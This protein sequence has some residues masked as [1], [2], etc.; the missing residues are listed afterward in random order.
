[1][2]RLFSAKNRLKL[3]GTSNEVSADIQQITTEEQADM[4]SSSAGEHLSVANRYSKDLY[5]RP[6][7]ATET[8]QADEKSRDP[9]EDLFFRLKHYASNEISHAL[10]ILEDLCEKQHM[11]EELIEDYK[12]LLTPAR[13]LLPELLE[14]IFLHCIPDSRSGE[15]HWGRQ[16]LE[17]YPRVSIHE[18]PW[19][20]GCVCRQWRQ[21]ALSTPLI[22]A[23]LDV[24]S[25]TSII[26][27][28]EWLDRSGSS[29]LS[30]T[31]SEDH[32]ALRPCSGAM[33]VLVTQSERWE[34]IDVS[35]GEVFP[36]V[37]PFLALLSGGLPSLKTLKIRGPWDGN[38]REHRCFVNIASS[39]RLTDISLFGVNLELRCG[40]AL[41]HNLR[42]LKLYGTEDRDGFLS[43]HPCL[44]ILRHTPCLEVVH[45]QI[46]DSEQFQPDNWTQTIELLHLVELDIDV[47]RG[48]YLTEIL[49]TLYVP[50]LTHLALRTKLKYCQMNSWPH[51]T[52]FLTHSQP[53]LESLKIM[54]TPLI[55]DDLLASLRQ[56]CG[57]HHLYILGIT[58][59]D[60]ILDALRPSSLQSGDS[61]CFCPLLRT[62]SIIDTGTVFSNIAI[63]TF[64]LSRWMP[65]TSSSLE[66]ED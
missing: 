1:M 40:D 31:L 4:K 64:I 36:H 32:P 12:M 17:R 16:D 46:P 22:W 5:E 65:Y 49:N 2:S 15:L 60:E 45:L 56:A 54:G 55:Q 10:A 25:N 21:V 38:W 13:R 62:I 44:S 41:L 50:A 29:S 19:K 9:S 48:D 35:F 11:T 30:F 42:V 39:L 52:S 66:T 14:M 33:D 59:T 61:T 28:K 34:N 43:I 7:K 3:N 23:E 37:E 20:I 18:A 6:C 51:L 26:G 27:L 57:L 63:T 53:P 58:V 47:P 8:A 24:N